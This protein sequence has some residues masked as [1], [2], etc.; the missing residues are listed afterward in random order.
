MTANDPL[1]IDAET[2]REIEA[3]ANAAELA[4]KRDREIARRCKRGQRALV[5]LAITAFALLT[6]SLNVHVY[7]GQNAGVVIGPEFAHCGV[8]LRGVPGP[9]CALGD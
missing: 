2:W 6:L 1:H 4:R 5:A 7:A 9:F 8:E 3:Y